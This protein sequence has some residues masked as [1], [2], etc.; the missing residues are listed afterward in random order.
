LLNP[1]NPI[2]TPDYRGFTVIKIADASLNSMRILRYAI[3]YL[4][5][6]LFWCGTGTSYII[7]EIYKW[8]S[9]PFGICSNTTQ[10]PFFVLEIPLLNRGAFSYE[11][12]IKLLFNVVHVFVK[13]GKL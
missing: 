2:I 10:G 11:T 1:D 3:E 13:N 12:D 6:F 4:H 9:G 5:F 7:A 8:A